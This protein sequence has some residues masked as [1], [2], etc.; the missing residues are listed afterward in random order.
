MLLKRRVQPSDWVQK[1][2]ILTKYQS[3]LNS[4]NRTDLSSWITNWQKVLTNAKKINLPEAEGL[5]PTQSFLESFYQIDSSF[6]NYWTNKLEDEARS[7]DLDWEKKFPIGIEISEIFE[8][9]QAT[10]AN[11]SS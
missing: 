5:R 1:K 8:R 7:N 10:K 2:E 3:T 9:T 4:P 6:S 11:M